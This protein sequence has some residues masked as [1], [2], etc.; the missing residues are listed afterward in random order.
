MAGIS[1]MKKKREKD[2]KKKI[3]KRRPIQKKETIE[4]KKGRA[5]KPKTH[6]HAGKS[7]GECKICGNTFKLKRKTKHRKGTIKGVICSRCGKNGEKRKTK[8]K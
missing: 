5:I 3:R 6:F 4:E 7:F 1:L 2:K 8:K